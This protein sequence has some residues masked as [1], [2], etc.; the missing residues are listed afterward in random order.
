ML[1]DQS[2]HNV[3]V[4]FLKKIFVLIIIFSKNVMGIGVEEEDK[5]HTW[6]EDVSCFLIILLLLELLGRMVYQ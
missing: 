6:M 4:Y 2:G 5:K 3:R 1:P